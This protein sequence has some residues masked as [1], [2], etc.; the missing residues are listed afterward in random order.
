MFSSEILVYSKSEEEHERHLRIVLEILRQ[1]KLYAKFS[2]CEFWLQQ[3]AF[4]GHIVSA[5]GIIMDPSKECRRRVNILSSVLMMTVFCGLKI[6]YM[7]LMIRH[8]A[9]K[10]MTEAHSS[11]FT[12]HPGS[13]K[14]YRDLK[15]YFWWNGNEA[16]CGDVCIQKD[17]L[18][19]GERLIEVRS[20]SRLLV[21]KVAVAKR[22][23]KRLDRDR[24]VMA[25]KQRR[26]YHYHPLHVASIPF[27]SIQPDILCPENLESILDR[28]ERVMRNKVIPFV[29]I[30]WKNHPEREATWETEESMRASV[31]E[32]KDRGKNIGKIVE[33][34]VQSGIPLTEPGFGD[35]EADT[36]R[37]IE[38]SLK[39]AHGA[40]RGPLPPVVFRE[41]DTGK[42]QPLPEVEGKGKEKVGAEQAAR[43]LLNLQT[44]KKKSPTEQYI[45]QRRTSAPTEPSGHDESSS[46]YAELGLTESDME[47]DEEVPP[48]VKSGAPDEGQAG[49]N[50]GIQDEGQ[51]G[52]NP[53][54]EATEATSQPQPGQMDEEFTA[55]TYPNSQE[56]LKLTV[57]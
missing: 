17:D 55:T 6:S 12:I 38:E 46:L 50:P 53:D 37:A 32:I 42:F 20:S 1:K 57:L 34:L 16:R 52:P 33:C 13:T 30:L 25:D 39:D 21:K 3:V 4:L 48:V 5:D 24:R 10:V 19:A 7:F 18:S 35:L 41:T 2:K 8:F 11:P 43:V 54:A 15:H 26:D 29:K 31:L 9:K 36:Q 56:N 40:H 22:R 51:A 23:R 28:Q 47:S 14:M 27:I 44:P 49:P 45:F